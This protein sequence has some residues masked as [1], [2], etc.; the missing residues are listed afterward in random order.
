MSIAF[1]SVFRRFSFFQYNYESGYL[2]CLSKSGKLVVKNFLSTPKVLILLA[3][4]ARVSILPW[5]MNRILIID[6]YTPCFRDSSD[7]FL[8]ANEVQVFESSTSIPA[9]SSLSLRRHSNYFS[10]VY[11]SKK[12]QRFFFCSSI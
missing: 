11:F 12:I 1:T 9:N 6:F 5:Q 8:G 7:R 4:G 3:F 10:Q 2:P